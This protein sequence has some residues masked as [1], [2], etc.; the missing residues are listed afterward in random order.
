MKKIISSLVLICSL[1]QA[2]AYWSVIEHNDLDTGNAIQVAHI[3]NQDGYSI[4]IYKD[5]INAVRLRFTSS[6][7]HGL[8]SS[9]YCPSFQVDSFKIFNRSINDAICIKHGQWSEFVLGYL[10]NDNVESTALY[11]IQ[12]GNK[13]VFRFMLAADGYEETTFTLA[14]SSRVILN[15]LGATTFIRKSQT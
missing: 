12:N 2:H 8:I 9:Q 4:E 7:K 14:G 3:K 13:L 15:V 1:Q 5:Q 11:R 6:E 10:E